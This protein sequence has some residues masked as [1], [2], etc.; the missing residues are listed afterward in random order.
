MSEDIKPQPPATTKKRFVRVNKLFQEDFD[1]DCS[2]HSGT[3]TSTTILYLPTYLWARS[4]TILRT[5]SSNTLLPLEASYG[6]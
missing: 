6:F 1:F 2:P 3:Y 4:A 5:L